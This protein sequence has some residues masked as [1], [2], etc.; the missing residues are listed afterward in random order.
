VTDHRI[1][2]TVFQLPR[3]LDG[4]LDMLIEPL[5][6]ADEARRLLDPGH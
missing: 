1:E 4:E 6:Q 5:M 3:V 2:L